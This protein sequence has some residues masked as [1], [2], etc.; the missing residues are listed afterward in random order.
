MIAQPLSKSSI[1]FS[2]FEGD[3]LSDIAFPHKVLLESLLKICENMGFHLTF[4]L[5][6]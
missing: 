4:Y 3:E 5:Y 2:L 1:K 6:K